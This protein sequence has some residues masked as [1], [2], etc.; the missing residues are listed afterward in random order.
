[1]VLTDAFG[2]RLRTLQTASTGA[3]VRTV[4]FLPLPDFLA[5][6]PI[7]RKSVTAS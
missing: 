1:M 4:N 5:I 7:S 6:L 3:S 2:D